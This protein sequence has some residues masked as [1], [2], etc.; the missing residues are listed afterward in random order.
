MARLMAERIEEGAARGREMLD[1]NPNGAR[2]AV[3]IFDGFVT[4]DAG[5]SDALIVEVRD[6]EQG[7]QGRCLIPYRPANNAAG[8]AVHR[9][10]FVL[11][12]TEQASLERL[13][14]AF[15]RGV[16]AHEQGA[17]VW[18]AALDESQ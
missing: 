13:A 8:F 1:T 5:R 11:E 15:F 9:P 10:K 16:D 14:Q 2:R 7:T 3:L 6:Y 18:A 4:L 17:A 12:Q